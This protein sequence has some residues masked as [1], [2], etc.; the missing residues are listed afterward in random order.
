MTDLPVRFPRDP[1]C[2]AGTRLMLSAAT[3]RGSSTSA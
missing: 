1:Y 3:E 2:R